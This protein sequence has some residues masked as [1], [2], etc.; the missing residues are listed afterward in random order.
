MHEFAVAEDIV[1]ASLEAI[2]SEGGGRL[3]RVHV[4]LAADDHIDPEILAEAFTM[5][6]AGTDAAEAML[7]VEVPPDLC[8]TCA[9]GEG[10]SIGAAVTAIEVST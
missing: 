9:A 3:E 6:A 8:P 7:D 4:V 2:E 10:P 1:A 5:A